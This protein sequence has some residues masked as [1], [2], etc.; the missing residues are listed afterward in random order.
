MR[1]NIIQQ[2]R[3]WWG[4]SLGAIALS[5][6]AMAISF[7]QLGAPI[8]PGLDFVGGTRLQLSLECAATETCTEVISPGIVRTILTPLGL[9]GSSIQVVEDYTLSV[10]TKT[11]SVEE[12]TQL[13][14]RLSAEI[15]AFDPTTIQIDTV[16]PTVGEE[17]LT[18][19]VQ[20]LL[21]SFF[22]IVVYLSFRFRFD[23]AV[24]AI[25]ALLHDAIITAGAFAFLGLTI[26]IEIDSL[27]LVAL[28]TII[29]FSVNDT[30]VIYDRIRETLEDS[31]PGTSIDTV[32]DEAVNQTLTRS[33]NTSLTTILPLLGIFFFGGETLRFFALAL[34]IGFLAGVYSSIFVAST[35]LAW[36]RKRQEKDLPLAAP[37]ANLSDE[38]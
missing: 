15:G 6:I 9:E 35:M 7:Q 1:L 29:G 2:R 16:G 25:L 22:G 11:L 32:V 28:L 34:I 10:R 27:F 17:L 13:T 31:E 5:L 30:V 23:Y 4:I 18:A 21:A 19:G 36:W 26:G 24:F 38:T 33:I 14:D 12:R 3:L 37:V 20:A 8:R